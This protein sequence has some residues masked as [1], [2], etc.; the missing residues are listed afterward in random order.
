MTRSA[1]RLSLAAIAFAATLACQKEPGIRGV[2]LE[3]LGTDEVQVTLAY[4]APESPFFEAVKLLPE[5]S[6]RFDVPGTPYVIVTT[7]ARTLEAE[8]PD[9]PVEEEVDSLPPLPP[10]DR[11]VLTA[12]DGARFYRMG[13]IALI[14]AI[15]DIGVE[16][17]EPPRLAPP[18]TPP[19]SYC[20]PD[21]SEPYRQAVERAYRRL[22]NLPDSEK[23]PW[24]GAWFLSNNGGSIDLRARPTRR[25]EDEGREIGPE[26]WLCPTAPCNGQN[27]SGQSTFALCGH[28]LPEHVGNDIMY[29]FVANHLS[30]PRD[31]MVLGAHWAQ[32]NTTYSSLDPPQSQAAYR[33]G[34]NLNDRMSFDNGTISREQF[35]R[36]VDNA[37]IYQGDG[38]VSPVTKHNAVE[39]IRAAYPWIA[40][41]QLCPHDA[42]RPATLLRDWTR[43]TWTLSDGSRVDDTGQ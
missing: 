13:G 2:Q 20:G 29:G 24:D 4:P 6:R 7:L 16:V 10:F 38:I 40:D 14:A 26:D 1:L 37:T 28:C 23:G 19:P 12:S 18:A 43:S 5:E 21:I 42:N 15:G 3:N 34:I 25:P 30:V 27:P 35:C 32:L 33:I 31:L 41:C 36:I 17:I 11:R 8:Q 39:F 9:E 22:E